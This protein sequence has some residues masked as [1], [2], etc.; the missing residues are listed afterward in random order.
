MDAPA[1][2]P[3]LAPRFE[4]PYTAVVFTS[5]RLP[6]ASGPEYAEAARRM[7]A[8][9]REQPG[10]LG[11]ESVSTPTTGITVSYW[12]DDA[13]A[14]AWKRVAEHAAV[15]G[16]GRREWYADYRIRVATVHRDAGL[17]D[18]GAEDPAD[19]PATSS[20]SNPSASAR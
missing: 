2:D 15:Q 16:R 11:I 3:L 5:A 13:A 20:T 9:A 18:H 10:Y 8:L 7:D 19:Q 14:R 17:H 12:R 6:A 1:G 4:P